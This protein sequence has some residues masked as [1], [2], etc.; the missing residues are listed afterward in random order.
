MEV[1]YTRA[2]D[3][4]PLGGYTLAFPNGAPRTARQEIT[5]PDGRYRLDVSLEF[6]GEAGQRGKEGPVAVRNDMS[7]EVSFTGTD[8]RVILEDTPP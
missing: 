8:I 1:A 4:E 7:R 6:R 5:A 3:S 2:G